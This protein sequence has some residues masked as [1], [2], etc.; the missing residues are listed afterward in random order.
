MKTI[1]HRTAF[2]LSLALLEVSHAAPVANGS[3]AQISPQPSVFN[4]V[5]YGAVGDDKTDNTEAFSAC[6]K[7]LVEAGGGRISLPTGVYRGRITIPP[8]SKRLPSW[9]TVEIVGETE[10][11]P[12]FGTIGNFP[13]QSHGTIIKCLAETGPAVISAGK[14]RSALYGNF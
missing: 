2:L 5:D 10:P 7:A 13:L 4:V 8:V 1:I 12:V 14:S 3:P 11:S 6:L 9:I